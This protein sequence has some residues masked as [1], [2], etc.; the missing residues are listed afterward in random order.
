MTAARRRTVL[1]IG[2]R[3]TVAL[4]LSN[5]FQ[6]ENWQVLFLGKNPGTYEGA[7]TYQVDV[8][9]E[10]AAQVFQVQKPNLLLVNLRA[11]QGPDTAAHLERILSL[12]EKSKVDRI[13]LIS[14][15]EVFAPG[16][17]DATEELAPNPA[18]EH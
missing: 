5:L 14:G 8:M 13:L 4:N 11:A 7:R 2:M 12:A 3:E 1:C 18:E 16:T 6:K 9:E 15:A 10:G 17:Q